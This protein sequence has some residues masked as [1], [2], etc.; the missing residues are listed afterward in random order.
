M[1]SG[2][3]TTI[4]YQCPIGLRRI[5]KIVNCCLGHDAKFITCSGPAN[6]LRTLS[7]ISHYK[8]LSQWA[9]K[10]GAEYTGGPKCGD[11]ICLYQCHVGRGMQ[12][13]F[14]TSKASAASINTQKPWLKLNVAI[15]ITEAPQHQESENRKDNFEASSLRVPLLRFYQV[16]YS[17]VPRL[18]IHVEFVN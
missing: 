12:C 15:V 7:S 5:I 10:C 14:A 3:R 2:S 11:Q 1:Q 18:N 13:S 17:H 4:S 8:P 9:I 6:H 16:Y